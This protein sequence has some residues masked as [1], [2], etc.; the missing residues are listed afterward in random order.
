MCPPPL[1]LLE[2]ANVEA[3]LFISDA[4]ALLCFNASASNVFITALLASNSF[5]ALLRAS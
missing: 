3:D 4:K 1:L 2:F 5:F